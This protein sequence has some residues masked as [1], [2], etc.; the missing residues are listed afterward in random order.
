MNFRIILLVLISILAFACGEDD[1]QGDATVLEGEWIWQFSTG[2]IGGATLTPDTENY[3]NEIEFEG[4][5]FESY[6]NDEIFSESEFSIIKSE[7]IFTTDSVDIISYTNQ[8]LIPQS[9]ELRSDT[10][11]LFDEV[12]DGFVHTYIKE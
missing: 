7:S 8:S 9:F 4:N 2:G 3:T 12:F 10:L 11:I 1:N 5:S 6:R